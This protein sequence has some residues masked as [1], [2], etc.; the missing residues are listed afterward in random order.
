[1]G[2][3]IKTF[4]LLALLSAIL[5][6]LG[7]AMGGRT[8]LLV[9]FGIALVMNVGSYW[10]SDKIVLNMYRARPLSPT[11]A[12][13]LHQMV[14][15][16]SKEAGIP[17]PR[18]YMVPDKSPNAF[19]TG[20]NPGHAA[21]AVTEGIVR[22]L[23]PEELRGVLAHEV[24]HIVNRDI[25]IQ[26]IAAVLATTIMYLARLAQYA[27]FFGTGR[28]DD[29][30]NPGGSMIGGL[31]LTIL[32]PV[33]AML[34]QMGIS[35]TREYKAD[36]TGAVLSQTPL[37]LASALDK[38]SRFAKQVPMRETDPGTAHM[39]I[40]SPL[41]G[42]F[43]GLFSTHPPVEQRISRLKAMQGEIKE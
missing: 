22:V 7:N 14:E 32:A 4:L 16:L 17:K 2:N 13:M 40:V 10:F 39:F 29:E 12:P 34:I 23:S 9:A 35:R 30:R 24:G 1:M 5:L 21:L 42:G 37:A 18:L 25:L 43:A 6:V 31:L 3:Q 28:G 19:A 27:A 36:K 15:Q 20:R 41:F 11:E 8:G 38:I 26:T 33:A